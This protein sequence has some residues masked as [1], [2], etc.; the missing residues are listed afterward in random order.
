[1]EKE[2]LE[3]LTFEDAIWDWVT[4]YVVTVMAEQCKGE[5]IIESLQIMVD[6]IFGRR[7]DIVSPEVFTDLIRFHINTTYN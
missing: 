1:M 7:R 6:E 3:R 2:P 5:A 4:V